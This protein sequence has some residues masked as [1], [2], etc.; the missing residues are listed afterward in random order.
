MSV[1][2]NLVHLSHLADIESPA[3]STVQLSGTKT[4]ET[5]ESFSN[6][7]RTDLLWTANPSLLFMG[8]YKL[9]KGNNRH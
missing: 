8:M 5:G 3:D 7:N 6:L 9:N 4:S 1:K 2:W